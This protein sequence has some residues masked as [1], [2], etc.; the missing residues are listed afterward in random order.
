[1]G[2]QKINLI[3]TVYNRKGIDGLTGVMS[4]EGPDGWIWDRNII[5]NNLVSSTI[6]E[7][8]VGGIEYNLD[9][10]ISIEDWNNF[11]YSNVKLKEIKTIEEETNKWTPTFSTGE[12]FLYGKKKKLYSSYS[13]SK[14]A[15][16]KENC[17]E[18]ELEGDFKI[19]SISAAIFTRN[20]N[21]VKYIHR[22][23]KYNQEEEKYF[24]YIDGNILK[25][26]SDESVN[27]IRSFEDSEELKL[28]S[29][30][31]G[32]SN[33]SGRTILSKF[34]PIE[35]GS[36]R[37]FGVWEKQI[38]EFEDFTGNK[39]PEDKYGFI[40]DYDLGTIF[41]SGK[42]Y[43]EIFLS[44]DLSKDDL[45]MEVVPVERIL[46]YPEEGEIEINGEKI[47]YG[48]K[49]KSKLYNCTRLNPQDHPKGSKMKMKNE[50]VGLG[51]EYEML[52]QYNTVPR[53]EFEV[54]DK[55]T[56]WS[57]NYG[58]LDLHP[59]SNLN[60][61]GIIQISSIDTNV[62]SINLKI[63][64]PYIGGQL[65]GP[66]F[67]GIDT[68]QLVATTLDS[69]GNE[70]EGVEVT[71]YIAGEGPGFLNGSNK[72]YKDFSNS[73]GE[74]YS[75]YNSPYDWD[76][77]SKEV[78]SV[79]H[80]SGSTIL[81][82]EIIE[83]FGSIDLSNVSIYEILK[84]DP[85]FGYRGNE[86]TPDSWGNEIKIDDTQYLKSWIKIK[87]DEFNFIDSFKGSNCL[88]KYSD[89]GT[90][91]SLIKE[92]RV[93]RTPGEMTEYLIILEER[94]AAIDNGK[95]VETVWI[96]ARKTVLEPE[97]PNSLEW[98][99]DKKIGA[100]KVLYEWNNFVTHPITKEMGAYYPVRP[101]KFL[102]R[103]QIQIEGKL[104][105][106]DAYDQENILG[107]YKVVCPSIVSFFATCRDPL[108][109]RTIVSNV[110]KLRLELPKYLNG[111]SFDEGLP[112][113]YGFGFVSENL[114]VGTGLG[115]QNFISINPIEENILTLNL[116]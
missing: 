4:A 63:N 10:G 81:E 79:R 89:G 96:Q 13:I 42:K 59:F 11:A 40:C 33:D 28:V 45:E 88:I 18:C 107:G 24:Y 85:V 115:G 83:E 67:F 111:V 15:I 78:F 65:Y 91:K 58:L 1:M 64:A 48:N 6:H 62:A 114:E 72:F 69:L 74:I 99:S 47:Y 38:I 75:Y 60:E 3:S 70:V 82:T 31:K 104:K 92:V 94:L 113:P 5:Q 43:E 16:R 103:N 50:G 7:G 95:T 112:I 55:D 53:I 20:K 17:F 14:S 49:S 106:P 25:T 68:K 8:Y 37:V 52:I 19:D 26:N 90:S 32:S 98:N 35:K 76:E 93:S 12:Y 101:K 9:E 100:L 2:V 66:G 34:F 84:H 102:S 54:S 56:R 86:F 22:E 23:W 61:N 44:K 108:T 77:I 116:K 29:E 36:L 41:T 71:I 51:E 21:S 73:E 27:L 46:T 105:I 80:E 39:I 110:I 97:Q 57:N 109:N 87:D 30:K